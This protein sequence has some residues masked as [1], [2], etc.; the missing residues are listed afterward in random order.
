M[1]GHFPITRKIIKK[2]Q[3]PSLQMHLFYVHFNQVTIFFLISP[4]ITLYIYVYESKLFCPIFVPNTFKDGTYYVPNQVPTIVLL[5][6][7]VGSSI[8]YL[9][10]E[11][12]YP[13]AGTPCSYKAALLP[14]QEIINH[15]QVQK[16]SKK[17]DM[18]IEICL[19]YK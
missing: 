5:C 19:D 9:G 7:Q 17:I 15:S 3:L 8:Y 6:I 13:E 18:Q 12:R 4:L 1:N 2:Y 16:C 14:W 11:R 10:G